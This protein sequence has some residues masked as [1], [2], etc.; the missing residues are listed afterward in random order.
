M[1]VLLN[2]YSFWRQMILNLILT[3]NTD[4]WLSS[5]K[6]RTNG[7]AS[8]EQWMLYFHHRESESCDYIPSSNHFAHCH[9]QQLLSSFQ[10]LRRCSEVKAAHR[11]DGEFCHSSPDSLI[12]K[13]DL[14]YSMCCGLCG[15]L[16]CTTSI[17]SSVMESLWGQLKY[18]A[19]D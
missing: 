8:L 7:R 5:S 11:C 9:L 17:L 14:S 1:E 15:A 2:Q 18:S 4:T 13:R 10:L 6:D 19:E 16:F 12:Q 3:L